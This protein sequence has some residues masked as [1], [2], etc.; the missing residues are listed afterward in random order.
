MRVITLVMTGSPVQ[1]L[2]PS[3]QNPQGN[4][5]ASLMMVQAN[6]ANAY[7]G[8]NTVSSSNGLTL[9][10][11]TVYPFDFSQPCGSLLSQYW[12]VGTDSDTVTVLYETAQ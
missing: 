3:A 5:A 6:T 11:G 8:D 9:T 4:V 2:V 7:M 12:F 10:S 1:L